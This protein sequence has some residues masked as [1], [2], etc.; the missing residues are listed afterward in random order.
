MWCI[1]EKKK[2][3]TKTKNGISVKDACERIND[4]HV[5]M[6]NDFY[7]DVDKKLIDKLKRQVVDLSVK[8]DTALSKCSEA[9]YLAQRAENNRQIYLEVM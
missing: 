8:I 1:A 5:R 7:N 3:E 4:D 2:E 9:E 6:N